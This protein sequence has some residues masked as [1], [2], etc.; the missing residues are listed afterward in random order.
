VQCSGASISL[1]LSLSVYWYAVLA[2]HGG[3]SGACRPEE[4][5]GAEQ[6]PR[7]RTTVLQREQQLAGVAT[8][9]KTCGSRRGLVSYLFLVKNLKI[10]SQTRWCLQMVRQMVRLTCS[11]QHAMDAPNAI[12]G[13]TRRGA[14]RRITY[15]VAAPDSSLGTGK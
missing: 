4:N 9:K 14:T 5:R 10:R 12:G 3:E 15:C 6:P 7:V 13:H 11:Y 2:A 1:S 8:K